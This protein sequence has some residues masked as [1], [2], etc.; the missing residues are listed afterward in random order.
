MATTATAV[1]SPAAALPTKVAGTTSTVLSTTAVAVP[2]AARPI[3]TVVQH[4]TGPVMATVSSVVLWSS[5][6][7][8]VLR[9]STDTAG[10]TPTHPIDAFGPALG[11]LH[12][13]VPASRTPPLGDTP[14]R[15]HPSQIPPL[16]GNDATASS[17]QG[18]GG[19]PFGALLPGSLV[20]PALLFG[21]V[22]LAREK[23][24]LFVFDLRYSPP[25]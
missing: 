4:V 7:S 19:N 14:V 6:G 25:G 18:Q 8:P 24:P 15:P 22:L 11:F 12:L 20:L 3:T 2:V 1:V 5:P 9:S 13:G 21:A 17:P 16:A 10:T 23:S